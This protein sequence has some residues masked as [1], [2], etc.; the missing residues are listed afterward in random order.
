[1]MSTPGAL[2]AVYLLFAFLCGPP[3][4]SLFICMRR[5]R[6]EQRHRRSGKRFGAGIAIS[7]AAFLFN[8]GVTFATTL[9]IARGEAA[10]GRLLALALALAW[11]CFWIWI[12]A[13]VL[14]ARRERNRIC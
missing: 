1:M 3:L 8:F 11:L 10:F 5:L 4:L 7:A 9:T 14:R 6:H 13:L 12:A 2:P